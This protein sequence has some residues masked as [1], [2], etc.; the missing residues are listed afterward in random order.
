MKESN[1]NESFNKSEIF[2]THYDH[3]T[4]EFNGVYHTVVNQ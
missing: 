1:N 2:M 4:I 3:E